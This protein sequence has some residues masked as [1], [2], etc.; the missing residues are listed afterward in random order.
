MAT[1]AT[2]T[3]GLRMG[4]G[5]GISAAD[6]GDGGNVNAL[7]PLRFGAGNGHVLEGGA[8]IYQL[9]PTKYRD[10]RVAGE[11]FTSTFLIGTCIM[12]QIWL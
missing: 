7:L 3:G 1:R 11:E 4:G 2:K 12:V 9:L 8:L 10:P 5:V 6:G